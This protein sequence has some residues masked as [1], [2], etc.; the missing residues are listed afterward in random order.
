[1]NESTKISDVAKLLNDLRSTLRTY[2]MYKVYSDN[3]KIRPNSDSVTVY[4]K[5]R[6]F[7]TI[8]TYERNYDRLQAYAY[9]IL[10]AVTLL[11][12]ALYAPVV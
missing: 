5:E 10:S 7:I 6:K 12:L 1:M 11:T 8:Y 2:S 4:I 3:I 9:S